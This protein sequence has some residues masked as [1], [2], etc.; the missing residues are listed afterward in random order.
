MFYNYPKVS[1]LYQEIYTK[2][3]FFFSFRNTSVKFCATLFISVV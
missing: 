3:D 2:L 1:F